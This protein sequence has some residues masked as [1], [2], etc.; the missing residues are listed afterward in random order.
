[1]SEIYSIFKNIIDLGLSIIPPNFLY[2]V[3]PFAAFI[4]IVNAIRRI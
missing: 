3:I 4:G 2:L 1:M